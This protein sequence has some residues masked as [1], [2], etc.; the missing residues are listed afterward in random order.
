MDLYSFLDDDARQVWALDRVT[1]ES[2]YL[3]DGSAKQ[4]RP[5]TRADLR[6]PYPDCA[7]PIT[8][9]GGE[10]RHHFRHLTD[11]THPGGPES[12]HHVEAKLMIADW[13]LR[14]ADVASVQVEAAVAGT[15]RRADVLVQP[16]AGR[17]LA[18]EVE[19]KA[20]TI[21]A[22]LAKRADYE[23]AGVD[24]LWLLGHSRVRAW[25]DESGR[26]QLPAFVAVLVEDGA[27]VLVVNP[28]TREIG[29]LCDPA[30]A[31]ARYTGTYT[32][33]RIAIAPLA[34]CWHDELTKNRFIATPA[35][36]RHD[37]TAR[38]LAAKRAAR[39]PPRRTRGEMPAAPLP[40]EDRSEAKQRQQVPAAGDAMAVPE[41][42]KSAIFESCIEGR[43]NWTVFTWV[44]ITRAVARSGK[45]APG[46]WSP[47]EFE[48]VRA[49]LDVLE[50]EGWIFV[51]SAKEFAASGKRTVVQGQLF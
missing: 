32:T 15:D 7:G 40:R 4:M 30:T 20:F 8:T 5:R 3:E 43:A 23:A 22:A 39:T 42:W 41:E 2:V 17:P 27:R 13:F 10:K 24:C 12:L 11:T 51:V 29:T 14:R 33:A 36:L 28:S 16:H 9:V 21:E 45:R 35:D 46:R 34:D 26:V 25:P 6:C 49:W 47:A 37:E 38:E 48:A 50:A 44:D 19:Y 31:D 18:I 1:G